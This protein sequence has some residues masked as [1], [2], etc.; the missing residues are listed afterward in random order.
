MSATKLSSLAPSENASAGIVVLRRAE[1]LRGGRVLCQNVNLALAPGEWAWLQ[2]PNGAGKTSLLRVLAGMLPLARGTRHVG[3]SAIAWLPADDALWHGPRALHD[4]LLFWARLSGGDA[5]AA[6]EKTGLL[7]LAARPLQHLSAGQKRRLSLARLLTA[8][9]GLWLLDE[10]LTALDRAGRALFAELLSSHLAAGGTAVVAI[11]EEITGM[12]V[13]PR[14]V[15]V[16][17]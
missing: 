13:P 4:A 12:D 16:G 14:I 17:A 10:P 6:L 9:A 5:A 7:P 11:H 2:G 15:Q 8:K 1:V 3:A